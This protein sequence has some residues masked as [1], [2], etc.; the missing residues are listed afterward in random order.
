MES[1]T[2]FNALSTAKKANFIARLLNNGLIDYFETC[3]RT[4]TG[5]YIHTIEQLESVEIYRND[6][7][8]LAYAENAFGLDY[9][10]QRWLELA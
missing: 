10:A 7:E 8:L 9:F 4:P 6:D 5:A 2:N 3:T 1:E